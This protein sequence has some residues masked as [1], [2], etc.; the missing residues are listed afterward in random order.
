MSCVWVYSRGE[1]KGEVCGVRVRSKFGKEENL[2]AVHCSRT[3][4]RNRARSNLIASEKRG[5]LYKVEICNS[6]VYKKCSSGDKV[7]RVVGHGRARE[8]ER[9]GGVIL[10]TA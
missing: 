7:V 8:L 6:G 9:L 2:C 1:K 5:V 3:T 4:E 10:G